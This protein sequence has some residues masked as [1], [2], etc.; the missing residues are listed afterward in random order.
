[1]ELDSTKSSQ[2]VRSFVVFIGM[3]RKFWGINMIQESLA[4]PR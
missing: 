4:F 3:G 1:M 2:D